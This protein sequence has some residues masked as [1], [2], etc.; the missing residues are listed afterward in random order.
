MSTA[1][2]LAAVFRTLVLAACLGLAGL[3]STGARA[4]GG[5]T[6]LVI[7]EAAYPD[8]D[9]PIP[10]VIA[11]ARAVADA[12]RRRGFAVVDAENADKA[13]MQAAIDRFLKSIEPDG[14]ALVFF[15]GYGIQAK[16]RNY[17]IPVDAR[18]WSEADVARDGISVDGLLDGMAKHR[19]GIR[20]TIL[21]ASRRN[22][23]ERR[24]RSFSQGLAPADAQPGTLTLYATAAGGV[25]NEGGGP[26]SLFVNELVQQIATDKSADQAFAATRDALAKRSRNGQVPALAARLDETFFF[27]PDR[28]RVAMP[29]AGPPDAKAGPP[30]AAARE[31][32]DAEAGARATREA[33]DRETRD[34]EARAREAKDREARETEAR[35][36]E[37]RSRE[38]RDRDNRDRENRDREARAR[39]AREREAAAEQAATRAFDAARASGTRAAYRDFLDRHPAGPLAERARSELA[40]LDAQERQASADLD[41][42]TAKDTP[43]AYGDFLARHPAGP[44]ADRARQAQAK[45]EARLSDADR[46]RGAQ[47]RQRLAELDDRIRRDPRDEAAYYERGQFHAQRGDAAAAIGD[48][49]QAIRLNPSSPEAFN[50]RCWM[51]AMAD[52]L[53]RALVDC[54]QALRLRPDFL[55][56]LDSRGLVHLKAGAL[57]AAITDYGDALRLDPRHSSALYG[58]G[59]ARRRLGEDGQAKRDIAGALEL[60]PQIDKEFASYGLH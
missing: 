19:A 1:R 7:A 18:I 41:E 55:D 29:K 47:E 12:L 46:R 26:T 43:A 16:R 2:S 27:D 51:R 38:A 32:A 37:V 14:I 35:D 11:D 42:A 15:S 22:P 33:R 39:D 52:D 10:T 5:R 13:A 25:L 21:D 58:R 9:A 6:A 44:L 3:G 60:N 20:V 53:K 28:A 24:F 23:F 48:F 56:A 31:T 4:A 54:D 57:R 17:L 40:R 45:A 59:L 34:R 8:S 49:D 30:D 50:N 36:D